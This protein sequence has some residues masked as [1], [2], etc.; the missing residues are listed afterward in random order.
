[1]ELDLTAPFR[2]LWSSLISIQVLA[3]VVDVLF[4]VPTMFMKDL[5]SSLFWCGF[6]YVLSS[7]AIILMRKRGQV[8]LLLL[9]FKLLL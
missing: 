2:S 8:A 6:I 4:Y 1:M 3:V 9:P 5:C 7:F